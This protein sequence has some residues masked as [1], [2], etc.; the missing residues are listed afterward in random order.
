MDDNVPD[1]STSRSGSMRP[2]LGR[3]QY[4][5][6]ENMVSCCAELRQSPSQLEHVEKTHCL[7]AVVL[8]LKAIGVELGFLILKTS[9]TST[10]KGP[11]RATHHR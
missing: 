11:A 4:L 5:T 10:V 3:T 7:G 9:E 1:T 8:T 6:G 2:E